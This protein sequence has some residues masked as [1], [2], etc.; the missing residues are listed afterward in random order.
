M[1]DQTSCNA[2]QILSK[3][4]VY[5]LGKWIFLPVLYGDSASCGLFIRLLHPARN[6]RK[7]I[8]VRFQK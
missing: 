3:S 8:N 4:F 2:V 7:I 1:R 5:K 6:D